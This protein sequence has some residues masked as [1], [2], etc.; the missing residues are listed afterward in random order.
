[1][2]TKKRPCTRK[3]GHVHRTEAMYTKPNP[4]HP[5]IVHEYASVYSN[6]VIISTC[7]VQSSRSIEP[8]WQPRLLPTSQMSRS[9]FGSQTQSRRPNGECLIYRWHRTTQL[10]A[11]VYCDIRC[12]QRLH[13]NSLWLLEIRSAHLATSP[14]QSPLAVVNHSHLSGHEAPL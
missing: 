14:A 7:I 6:S 5:K 12:V 3:N 9:T 1:M 10:F 2:Y 11:G 4:P 13:S 8:N